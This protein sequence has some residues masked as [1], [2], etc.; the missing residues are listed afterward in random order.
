MSIKFVFTDIDGTLTGKD[1]V[2]TKKNIDAI[3]KL[4]DMGIGFCLQSGRL[5]CS[6]KEITDELKDCGCDDIYSI[7]SNG[8]MII[9]PN[10]NIFYEEYLSKNNLNICLDYFKLLKDVSYAL[11]S[12]RHYYVIGEDY[13][14]GKNKYR[15]QV[16]VHINDE[17]ARE[18]IEKEQI[19]KF[20]FIDNDLEELEEIIKQ[21]PLITN[22]EVMAVKSSYNAIEVIPNG[23]SKGNGLLEF[24]KYKNL[25]PKECLVV[26]DNYNDE[27]M[28]DIAGYKAC[29]SNAVDD[30]KKK[31]DY[32]SD[33]DC[34]NSAV[35]DV[36]EHFTK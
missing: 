1:H 32:I 11:A 17:Y 36:I 28:I 8:S 29:P 25:D 26:G 10:F 12:Y 24:C 16:N 34:F 14:N 9:D 33:Y 18:L 3:R 22:G 23:I 30:I 27:S 20:L 15:N 19:A 6:L 2:L 13:F 4:K 7:C 35:A 21:I 31:C 5:P